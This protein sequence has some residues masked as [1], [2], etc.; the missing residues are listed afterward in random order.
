MR[1]G[2]GREAAASGDGRNAGKNR[3]PHL[4]GLRPDA[5]TLLATLLA[6]LTSDVRRTHRPLAL[7]NGASRVASKVAS[8]VHTIT[9]R[10]LEIRHAE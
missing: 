2:G 3:L 8:T 10:G 1:D 4:D 9:H 5:A 7:V 6:P